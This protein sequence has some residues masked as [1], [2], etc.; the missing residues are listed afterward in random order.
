MGKGFRLFAAG[1]EWD[2]KV[3]SRLVD[4]TGRTTTYWWDGIGERVGNIVR[5]SVENTVGK[6]CRE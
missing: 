4:G 1:W 6:R 3:G 5:K 2:R